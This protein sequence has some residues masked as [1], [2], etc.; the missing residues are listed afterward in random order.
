MKNEGRWLAL[1]AVV[2]IGLVVAVAAVGWF[3]L[4]EAPSAPAGPV[5]PV[6][7]RVESGE[8]FAS[9]ARRL[10]EQGLV[11]SADR[12]EILGRLVGAD[13]DIR[14]GTYLLAVGTPPRDLIGDLVAGNVRITTFTVPEGWRLDQIAAAAESALGIAPEE[15]LV[16]AADSELRLTLGCR[17]ETLEGYLFPETYHFTDASTAA[18]VVNAMAGR[19][20][21]E[22]RSLEGAKGGLPEGLDRHGVVT[23]ASIVEAETSVSEERPH[24]AAVY[25]NRLGLGWRLQ[26]DPT[27]RYAMG[28]FNGRLYYKHLEIDSPYNT[29]RYEGLPPG[30]IAAPGLAA[31]EAVFDPLEPCDDLF[32]VAS[33]DGGHIFSRTREEHDRAKRLARGR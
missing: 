6:E 7:F 16:A 18:D 13:R 32:F 29:Y 14:V 9:V 5:G 17:S 19:F 33:G 25:L 2:S 12:F 3:R 22:W 15:F 23:L 28:R 30:P 4:N 27:V 24:V 21:A 26:A 1:L 11:V 8:G 31:M 10:E 20:D